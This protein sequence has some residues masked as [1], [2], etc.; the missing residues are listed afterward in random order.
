[1]KPILKVVSLTILA[2]E[3]GLSGIWYASNTS[4]IGGDVANRG[5]FQCQ[6][7]STWPAD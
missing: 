5:W 3:D 4:Q 7:L 1:M 6:P 2:P